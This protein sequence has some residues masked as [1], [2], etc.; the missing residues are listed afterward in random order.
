MNKTKLSVYFDTFLITTISVFLLYIWI[1]KYIKNAILSFFICNIIYFLLFFVIFKYLNNKLTISN[2]KTKDKKICDFILNY[3]TYSSESINQNFFKNLLN[4]NHISNNYFK[5]E[6]SYFYID[7]KSNLDSKSFHKINNFYLSLNSNLP[8]T[9]IY[10]NYTPEFKELILNNPNQFN[11]INFDELYSI[12]K[13]KNFYP[14]SI[15]NNQKSKL[16]KLKQI[17]Q[18]TISSLTKNNFFK[19]LFS[20]LSLITLS[21]FIPFSFYYLIIGSILI[22]LSII[23]LFNKSEKSI[24]SITDLSSLIKKADE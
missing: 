19:F 20:G 4:I 16:K 5:N 17:K 7:I 24:K 18:K 10:K 23:S 1:N 6:K 12:M 8:L 22:I 21:L 3:L 15:T 2:L 9:I 11:L 14:T 13:A